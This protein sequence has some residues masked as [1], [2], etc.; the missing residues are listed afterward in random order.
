MIKNGHLSPLSMAEIKKRKGET[1]ESLMRRFR[2][3]MQQSGKLLQAKKVRF[4]KT[5]PN[6]TK[7]KHSALHRLD[8]AKRRAY[9]AKI[10]KLPVEERPRFGNR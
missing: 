3:R 9:L 4:L 1:F 7:R 6:K 5:D 8:M 2:R 10:G